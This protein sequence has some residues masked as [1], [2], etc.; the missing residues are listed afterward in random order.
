[1]FQFGCVYGFNYR[2]K[3]I[4]GVFVWCTGILQL[5]G[6]YPVRH[7]P[8]VPGQGPRPLEQVSGGQDLG[9]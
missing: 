3:K 5:F 2:D 4:V 6:V 9:T 8:C 7:Q 1:L